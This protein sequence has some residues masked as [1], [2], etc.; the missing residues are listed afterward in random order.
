MLRGLD[1]DS[2]AYGELLTLMSRYLRGYFGRRL[3]RR[4]G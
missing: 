1:G 2:G 4:R 3:G